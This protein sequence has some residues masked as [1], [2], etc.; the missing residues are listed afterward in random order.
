GPQIENPGEYLDR[1]IAHRLAREAK[2]F[3]ALPTGSAAMPEEL[4]PVVYADTPEGMHPIAARSLQAHLEKLVGDGRVVEQD[5][6]YRSL[7]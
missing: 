5:G 6:G 3:Q 4:L 2:V 7:D 1:Y